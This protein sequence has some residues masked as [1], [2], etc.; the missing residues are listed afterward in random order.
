M[1][2]STGRLLRPRPIPRPAAE[3]RSTVFSLEKGLGWLVMF[4][5]KNSHSQA[6]QPPPAGPARA[7][8]PCA[9]G[10]HSFACVAASGGGVLSSLSPE[11][12]PK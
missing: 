10:I 7:G 4:I 6:L 11:H 12:V 5:C 3:P 1:G 2:V 8:P 9:A